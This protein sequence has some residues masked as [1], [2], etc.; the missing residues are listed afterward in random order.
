MASNRVPPVGGA[1]ATTTT[2]GIVQLTDSTSSTSTTTAATPASVKSA[3]DLA[4]AAIPKNLTTTTG[5]IIYASGANTPARLGIG[6]TGNVLTV[7]GGV[8]TW[9]APSGGGSAIVA[10]KNSI[11]NG[12]FSIWQRGTSFAIT[13]KAY[14]ADRWDAIRASSTS[15]LTVSRQTTSDT[16]NLPNI[17]YCA[18]VQRDSGNSSTVQIF[19]AQS[20][21]S[22]NSIPLAGKQVTLSFYA[23]RGANYSSSVS[24]GLIAYIY[25]GT[26]TDQNNINGY[27]GQAT[28]AGTTATLT[29]TWTRFSMSGTVATTATELAV[30]FTYNPTGTA[31]AA[32]Y[33]EVTGVQLEVGASATDFSRAQGTISA[34]LAA[35]QRYYYQIGT[36][37]S[38]AYEPAG[39]I[40]VSPDTSSFLG[41]V[42]YPVAMRTTPTVTTTGTWELKN[43]GITINSATVSTSTTLTQGLLNWNS[44]GTTAWRPDNIR[45]SNSPGALMRFSAEL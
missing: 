6:S 11:L 34:E 43:Q 4:N 25:S 45:N 12:D 9:S 26:G 31:G 32:D 39:L 38:A 7:S 15:G 23:R 16:T 27:T 44:S 19:F 21:E 33:F 29:T 28:V 35:C 36:A 18:R 3:Y 20:I 8:P 24:N 2:S 30:Q 1:T 13:S 42:Q 17:Q 14:T 41:P 10:G 40:G 5:D 22:V 37:S